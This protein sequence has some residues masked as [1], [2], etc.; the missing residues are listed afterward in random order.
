M[1]LVKVSL[2]QLTVEKEK[3]LNSAFATLKDLALVVFIVMA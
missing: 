3:Y 1:L 2:L